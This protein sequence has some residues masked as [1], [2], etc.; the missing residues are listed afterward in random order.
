MKK[1]EENYLHKI[2]K[3]ILIYNW[4]P[5]DE[6]EGKGG[7]VSVYT[8]NLIRHL[9]KRS[10]WEVYFLSSGRAYDIR[11]RKTF[12]EPTENIFGEEC[13]SYQ[14]VNSPVLSSAHLSFSSPWLCY[15]DTV[16]K[17]VIKKF[18]REIGDFDVVHF[19]NLEGLSLKVLE[20]KE[21]FPKTKFIYSLHNYYPFCPQVMLWKENLE[22]CQ[23]KTGGECCISCMPKDVHRRK[24][25]F[26]QWINYQKKREEKIRPVWSGLQNVMESVYGIYDKLT[27]G[28]ICVRRKIKLSRAFQRFRKEMVFYL[29]KYMDDILAVSHRTAEIATFYGVEK[30]KVRISYIGSEVAEIQKGNEAYPYDGGLFHICYLGYMRRVKGFHFLI[31]ALEKMP[32]HLAVKLKLTL[33]VQ[34]REDEM[35]KRITDL[36][37]KLTEI[38]IYDGYNHDDLP[39]ILKEVQLGIVPH[40]WEDNL[41]QVAIEMKAYGIPVLVSDLGGAREL[42]LSNDFC[43]VGGDIDDFLKK[44]SVFLRYP[45]KLNNYWKNASKLPT[46]G[47]H[48]EELMS[49]YEE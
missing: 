25:I 3:K 27:G 48:I 11:K 19:Q 47:E 26:N 16:L 7:G 1:G 22:N 34:I 20:L 40:L 5:F 15:E 14:I 35:K 49:Y 23:E 42:T 10:D 37:K 45:E 9:V 24:V 38:V 18:F 12:I 31:E 43:F 21:E 6:T 8:K 30:E 46:M 36:K 28:K 17:E 32:S 29:N 44:L 4:I 2:M 41:P 39:E 33:A 13:K